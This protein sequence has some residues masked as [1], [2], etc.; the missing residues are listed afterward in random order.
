MSQVI[1]QFENDAKPVVITVT[2]GTT[3][4]EAARS[5]N[6][7]ID[8]PCSGNGSCGK[9]RVKLVSGELT[10]PQTSH[11]SDEEY[12]DGWR[13]S[14]CMHVAS[15]AVVLVPDIASAYRSRMKTADLS[16]GEEIRIFEELLA[17]VQGAGISLGN[18]FRAVDLQLDEPTLDDTMPDNERLT[19]ALEAQD[20]IDAV[21]LPWYAMRRLP[22]A[23]RDN[24][25][26]VRVLGELQNGIFTVFDVTGQ[27][28]TLPMCG[29]GIDIGTSTTQLILS[30]L[31][32]A[33]R[34]NPFSVPRIAI[35][36]REVLYRSG[37]HF[38]PLLSDTVIDAEGVRTIVAEEYRKSGFAP[39]QVDTGAVIITGETARK[40]N[41]R[42]VLSALSQFAGDFVV[43]T[44]GPDLESI[45]A[46]RGAGA[47]E[48]SREH[49][50]D[51]LHFDIGGGTSNL[52]LY[53][54]GELAATGCLDVG[55][56]LI[57][58]DREGTVTYVSPV[59]KRGAM[60]ASPPTVGQKA[61]P[62]GLEPVIRSMVEALEQAAG[63]RPGRDR[64][65]AFL[66]QGT[67]W[68]PRAVPVVSFSGGVADCI[69]APPG[70]WKAYGDIGVL[71][72]RAIAAS[73]AFQGAGRFRGEETIRATVVGAGSHSTELSGSTI[74]YRDIAFPLK[75]L[76]ILK[77]TGEEERGDAAALAQCI[78]DK[79][80]WFADEGGLSPLA[81]A[82]RGEGNPSYARVDELARG[83]AGGLEPLRAQ[84]IAPVVLVEA[85]QAKVLGQ[86][87]A[88][89]VEGPLLCLDS[90]GVDNGDYIDIGAPVAGGAVLPVVIKTLVFNKS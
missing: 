52:A 56:R 25:F 75:N 74:Y 18:G 28:D 11:I 4:L 14:C 83:I 82:L 41:A 49:H 46:A 10:G 79:L 90:V 63:L 43:A 29:V 30:R 24:A 59:L 33:N 57:K 16:S 45:L 9:C 44:A 48:Y 80:G 72:G 86:A 76:P 3:L 87:M 7:A 12:A 88:Q 23:L 69:Y 34:A 81:L 26:A 2:P 36:D 32:L 77:L 31:T 38:T 68:E 21:R 6:V 84:G 60:W 78:R 58:L 65:D 35:E 70:D 22:K 71:L 13:L 66:T 55:G 27:N 17:G 19:R 39:E 20:G 15:D 73:P 1:F 61:A 37:I 89:R 40:E 64:L 85:D 42:E 62:E 53:S 8:A 51:V 5:A 50:T 47:D 67:R 54:H